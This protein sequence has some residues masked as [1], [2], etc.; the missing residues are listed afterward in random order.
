MLRTART[1]K[2]DSLAKAAAALGCTEMTYSM[3]E[4]DV[5]VP[6]AERAQALA[7]YVGQP[8]AVILGRLGVLSQSE[9]RLLTKGASQARTS[10]RRM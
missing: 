8:R 10:R 3:W 5:W 4:R 9:V 2:G 7:D 1:A 6:K